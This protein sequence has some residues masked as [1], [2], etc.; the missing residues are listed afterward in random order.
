MRSIF[1]VPVLVFASAV[2]AQPATQPSTQPAVQ[3]EMSISRTRVQQTTEANFFYTEVETTIEQIGAIAGPTIDA[4]CAASSKAGNETAGPV[5]FVYFGATEN[6]KQKFKLQIG[7]LVGKDSTESGD[8][9]LRKLD[10]AKVASVIYCGG[11][12]TI[13][14]GYQQLFTDLF[15]RGL[16]PT[17]E[18]RE[19]YLIWEGMESA[20]N[21]TQI[22]VVVK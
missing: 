2:F 8:F 6:P 15:T 16:Q 17:N 19:S 1:L 12:Q 20:N 22:Q 3:D 18:I 10:S 13:Q 9:K 7:L 14:L 5:T 4:L 21:V 11:M